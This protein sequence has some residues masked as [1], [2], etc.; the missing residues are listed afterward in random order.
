MSIREPLVLRHDC[1]SSKICHQGFCLVSM[2]A[3]WYN[4]SPFK[5]HN[6]LYNSEVQNK[7]N[8]YLIGKFEKKLKEQNAFYD[9]TSF[10]IE[11]PSIS[12][13]IESPLAK[14][15]SLFLLLLLRDNE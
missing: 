9:D 10:I 3:C 14:S 5:E 13:V 2:Q 6:S 12:C 4:P 1:N 15:G 7:K 11:Q 8:P